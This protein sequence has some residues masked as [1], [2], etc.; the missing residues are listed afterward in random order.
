MNLLIVTLFSLESGFTQ[1]LKIVQ[2]R[3]F[4]TDT[5]MNFKSF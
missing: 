4:K 1:K 5:N 2:N 3:K